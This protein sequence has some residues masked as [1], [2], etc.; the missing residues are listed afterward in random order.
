MK[1]R[2]IR[3]N[4]AGHINP[5]TTLAHQ[6]QA[7]NYEVAFLY[8]SEAAG[9]PRIRGSENDQL[10]GGRREVSATQGD[11]ALEFSLGVLMAQTEMILEPLS[12]SDG[13]GKEAPIEQGH[14]KAR[15][16]LISLAALISFLVGILCLMEHVA[17]PTT[18]TD[19]LNLAA[20]GAPSDVEVT[21]GEAI[22]A[23]SVRH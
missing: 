12:E 15:F 11:A 3:L 18:S 5:M 8:Q 9:L 16:C 19:Q 4:A 22:R 10:L 6:L 2:F 13:T 1:P 7:R 23:L 21:I 14:R 20:E 17:P